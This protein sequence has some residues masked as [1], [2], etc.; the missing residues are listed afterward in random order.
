MSRYAEALT[1]F[2]AAA[3]LDNKYQHR[4]KVEMNKLLE[5]VDVENTDDEDE[6]EEGQGSSFAV[7][8]V[9]SAGEGESGFDLS[10]DT[11]EAISP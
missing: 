6:D 10:L 11:D 8:V 1:S 2:G 4:V 5:T 9:V 7:S 3:D